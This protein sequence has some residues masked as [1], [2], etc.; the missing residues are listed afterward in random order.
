MVSDP[1]FSAEKVSLVR[2]VSFGGSTFGQK[3]EP[4]KDTKKHQE[5]KVVFCHWVK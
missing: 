5:W 2:F 3:S 1:G 4:L